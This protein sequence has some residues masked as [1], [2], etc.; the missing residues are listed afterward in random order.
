MEYSGR[1]MGSTRLEAGGHMLTLLHAS[2]N[3]YTLTQK[4][5]AHTEYQPTDARS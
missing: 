2:A 1:F 3:T 5:V 4:A